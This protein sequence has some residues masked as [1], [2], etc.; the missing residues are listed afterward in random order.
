MEPDMLTLAVIGKDSV[1]Y[2]AYYDFINE[3]WSVESGDKEVNKWPETESTSLVEAPECKV[4]LVTT[5]EDDEDLF[6]NAYGMSE[7]EFDQYVED[8]KEKGFTEDVYESEK[9]YSADD[10]AGNSV[11]I[12]YDEDTAIMDFVLY[13]ADNE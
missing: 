5:D 8:L 3:S 1:T 13:A 2:I 10:K 11:S 7:D 12:D 4:Y 6:F 9:Y